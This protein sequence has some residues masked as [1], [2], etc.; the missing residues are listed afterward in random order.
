MEEEKVNDFK[1][2]S[3]SLEFVTAD[4]VGKEITTIQ[5]AKAFNFLISEYLGSEIIYEGLKGFVRTF[6]D[7]TV[8]AIIK[9]ENNQTTAEDADSAAPSSNG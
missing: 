8:E 2:Y 7:Q 1:Q 4:V 3:V 6:F 5:E 9:D